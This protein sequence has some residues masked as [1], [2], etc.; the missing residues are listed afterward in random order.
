VT[1]EKQ[2][3]Q[4]HKSL[5]QN[6]DITGIEHRELSVSNRDDEEHKLSFINL[7]QKDQSVLHESPNQY[8]PKPE[9]NDDR[10]TS[11]NRMGPKIFRKQPSEVSSTH[12]DQETQ[13]ED[14]NVPTD[15]D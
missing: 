3:H 4:V 13:Y 8:L 7:P 15:Q 14:E 6:I 1:N 2:L 11:K 12:R 5:S 9:D 10:E